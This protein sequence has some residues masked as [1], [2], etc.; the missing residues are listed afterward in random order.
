[1]RRTREILIR[2]WRLVDVLHSRRLGASIAVL[3]EELQTSRATLYRDLALLQEAGVR[4]QA[5]RVNGAFKIRGRRWFKRA[6]RAPWME[7]H[8]AVSRDGESQ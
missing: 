3:R 2:L 8:K 6:D 5:D 1:M 4:I 7:W